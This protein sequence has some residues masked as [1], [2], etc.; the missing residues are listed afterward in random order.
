MPKVTSLIT[1]IITTNIN[2]IYLRMYQI[3]VK[4]INIIN[5]NSKELSIYNY[6]LTL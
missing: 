5:I 1:Y 4:S 3:G 2:N 6:C